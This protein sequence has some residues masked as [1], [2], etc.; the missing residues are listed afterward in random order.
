M[1]NENDTLRFHI[2]SATGTVEQEVSKW[3]A[4]VKKEEQEA[5]ELFVQLQNKKIEL[6]SFL[7]EYNFKVGTFYVELDKIKLKIK[8]YELRLEFLK[9]KKKTLENLGDIEGNVHDTFN[10]ERE[11]IDDLGSEASDSSE[12]Y[13]KQQEEEKEPLLDKE[14][15]KEL[16]SIYKELVMKY[17][18]DL[19][20]DAEKKI[21]NA[22]IMAAI[23]EAYSKKDLET[24]R[25][26]AEK[27]RLEEKIAKETPEE[28]LARLKDYFGNLLDYIERLESEI[29]DFAESDI[30]KLKE[31]FDKAQEEGEDLFEEIANGVKKE[32]AENM[33]ILDKLVA[34]YKKI[35]AKLAY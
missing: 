21:E 1:D 5:S 3:E 22:N 28:K 27:S 10:E 31:K 23:N 15:Q 2:V 35:L 30:C 6:N 19:V 14:S 34:K 17:H 4:R 9:D 16:E 18:P 26:Y 12:E 32:I 7:N 25:K 20:K 13:S 24:L 8:E 29:K 11:R 33:K